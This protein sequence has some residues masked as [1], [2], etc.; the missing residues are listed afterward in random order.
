MTCH[1]TVLTESMKA[2]DAAKIICEK[3][4]DNAPVVNSAGVVIGIVD[5]GDLLPFLS[6]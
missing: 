4:I 3:Q 2:V 6:N 5:E 1:P